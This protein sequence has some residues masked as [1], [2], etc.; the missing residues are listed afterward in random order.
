MSTRFLRALLLPA[1][2]SIQACNPEGACIDQHTWSSGTQEDGCYTARK[3]G[4]V[5]APQY[6]F[7]EGK[8]CQELGYAAR[9]RGAVGTETYRKSCAPAR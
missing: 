7:H 2:V 9:C 4:C 1:A 6:T 3:H 8:S 5:P